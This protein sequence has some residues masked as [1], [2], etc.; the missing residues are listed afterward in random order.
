MSNISTLFL[1]LEEVQHSCPKG[2]KCYEKIYIRSIDFLQGK[3]HVC[4]D[5]TKF[6]A[7][8]SLQTFN[9]FTCRV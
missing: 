3:L 7:F 4:Y 6:T 1:L 2:I 8:I 5:S 9:R